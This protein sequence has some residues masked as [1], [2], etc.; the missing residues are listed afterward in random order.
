MDTIV[1]SPAIDTLEKYDGIYNQVLWIEYPVTVGDSHGGIESRLGKRN[2]GK[3]AS[4]IGG[5]NHAVKISELVE[6][7]R[8]LDREIIERLEKEDAQPRAFL[9]AGAKERAVVI[10]VAYQIPVFV[11]RVP[12]EVLPYSLFAKELYLVGAVGVKELLAKRRE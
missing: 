11:V 4:V 6:E 5:M 3:C 10:T 1:C 12:D 7:K 9:L 8:S 2:F